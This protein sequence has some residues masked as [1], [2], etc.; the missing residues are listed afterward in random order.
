MFVRPTPLPY[1][2]DLWQQKPFAERLQMVCRA[3]A[4]QGYG[5]PLAVYG[6]YLVKIAG[7][8][9]MWFFFCSRSD[10]G[11]PPSSVGSWWFS[12][13]ALTKAVLWSMLYEG[14]GFGC[15]SGPLTG[16]YFPPVGGF[17]HFLWPGTTKLPLFAKLPVLGGTRRSLLDVFLYAAHCA[18]LLRALLAP[19][20]TPALL[21]PTLVLLPILGLSDKTIFLASR[22]EHY[23]VALLCLFSVDDAVAGLKWV[24][25]AIW[26]WAAISK[27]T[28]H[29]PTV[30]AVMT[31]NNPFLRS[32]FIRKR[33]YRNFP[34][35]L[36]PSTLAVATAHI[37]TVLEALFPLLLIAS[38]GGVITQVGLVVMLVFHLYITSNVPMAVPIEWNVVMV[39]GAFLLFGEHAEVVAWHMSHSWLAA[40]LVVAL[41]LVPL[42]G[43][44]VPRYV[45]FLLSMRYYAGNWPYSIW[46][47]RA[48]SSKKLEKLKKVARSTGDQLRLFYDDK[49]ARGLVRL[50]IAFS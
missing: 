11:G 21:L 42:V 25:F 9:A 3:W 4:L 10:A 8:V 49:T 5:A 19:E 47:F 27:M 41:F 6:A 22:A 37:G 1:D 24:W 36:R 34:D 40:S 31:S 2:M 18:L 46:L 33:L 26:V 44:F 14:L 43:N 28:H 29:F 17:L 12:L 32:A 20:V 7:Y 15:G 35:D 13:E 23:W 39:Y 16:R 45:S 50:G 30:I 38:T 48:D